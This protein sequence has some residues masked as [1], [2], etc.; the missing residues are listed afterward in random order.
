M[1]KIYLLIL[2]MLSLASIVAQ[3]E[4]N[5]VY[6]IVEQGAEFPGGI[7]EF[8]KIIARN[9]EYPVEAKAQGIE[10]KVFVQ[11]II[12]ESG[13]IVQESVKPVHSDNSKLDA[14]AVR[15]IKSSPTWN[16][17]RHRG[18]TVK[19]K[20]I[21]PISFKLSKAQKKEIRQKKNKN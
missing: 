1:E 4:E 11:F 2:A 20:M 14:E 7:K 18:K 9:L 13:E 21:L 19:Q 5:L 6:T 10:G 16:A 3:E 15:L 17:G 12:D 8:Y